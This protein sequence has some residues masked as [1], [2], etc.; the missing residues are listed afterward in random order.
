[1]K[2]VF[3]DVKH[4][5]DLLYSRYGYDFRDYA[6]ASLLRRVEF[7]IEKLKAKSADD[8]LEKVE[9]KTV[10]IEKL[11]SYLTVSTTEFFRDPQ[12][13]ENFRN[14][15]VPRLNTFPY[16]R[17]WIAGTST[18]EEV[19]SYAIILKEEGL[20]E[21]CTLFATDINKQALDVLRSRAYKLDK[22]KS[23]YKNYFLSGGKGTFSS[24]FSE[25]NNVC[26][27]NE[28]LLSGVIAS[29]Y[30]LATSKSFSE[31][32]YVSCRNTLIY[33][34]KNLQKKVISLF[35]N[36]LEDY[37]IL[38]IGNQESL[39]F[40]SEGSKKDLFETLVKPN[41]YTKVSAR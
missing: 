1:M 2:L 17:L 3:A 10:S 26:L 13:F 29:D 4:F 5:L 21:R 27:F 11:I 41:F 22:V 6:E 31:V 40:L 30:C 23:S 34:K 35:F 36:N 7:C 19:V 15:V 9:K 18:G 14:H 20:L 33:F 39:A 16:P 8:L 38:G 12:F 28:D 37:G 24:H 32:Q 25:K